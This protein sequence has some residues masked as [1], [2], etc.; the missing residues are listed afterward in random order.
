VAADYWDEKR[1]NLLKDL[2]KH[3]PLSFEEIAHL[4][5]FAGIS[6]NAIAGKCKRL[7]L[8]KKSVRK[9]PHRRRA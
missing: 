9:G 2:R 8:C 7:G 4:P 6:R 3:S 1:V 5:E